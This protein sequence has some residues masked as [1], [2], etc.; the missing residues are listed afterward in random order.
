[1]IA[2]RRADFLLRKIDGRHA[3]NVAG[4]ARTPGK[5]RISRWERKAGWRDR[6]V[7]VITIPTSFHSDELNRGVRNLIFEFLN[8]GAVAPGMVGSI[9]LL[10]ALYAST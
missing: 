10:V 9:S 8:P 2:G 5:P 4:K 3:S 7:A 1:V 6:A